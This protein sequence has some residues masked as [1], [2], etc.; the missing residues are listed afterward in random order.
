MKRKYQILLAVVFL[1]NL[2]TF[3]QNVLTYEANAMRCLDKLEYQV[4]GFCDPG[5]GGCNQIWNFSS[6]DET[7]GLYEISFTSDSLQNYFKTEGEHKFSFKLSSNVLEQYEIENRLSKI[8]YFGKKVS[9]KFPFQY[10]DSVHSD[11]VGYGFYCGE[12]MIKEVG[13]VV[14]MADGIGK[15]VISERDTLDNVLRIHSKTTTKFSL[16]TE[17]AKLDSVS[18]KSKIEDRYEWYWK[19]FRYPV[20]II[21]KETCFTGIDKVSDS[22]VCY[23]ILPKD[24]SQISDSVNEVIRKTVCNRKYN[25]EKAIKE[26]FKY[27]ISKNGEGIDIN[28]ISLEKAN[29]VVLV[30]SS[31][32]IIYRR[33]SYTMQAGETGKI[34]LSTNGLNSGQYVLYMNVNGNILSQ[35][36]NV[37]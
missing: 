27:D 28:Y 13:H 3:G 1:V 37:K 5:I 34:Q 33:N 26:K 35:S 16:G 23:R 6:V 36:I 10:L 12:H 29:I 22:F 18:P 11:F 24:F 19:G 4:M 20:F 7:S 15:L 31:S 2:A 30:A 32:G 25:E 14:V 21:D 17:Y 8:R 9:L